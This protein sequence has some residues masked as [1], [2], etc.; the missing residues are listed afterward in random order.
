MAFYAARLRSRLQR[1]I[2]SGR[3]VPRVSK[4]T[5]K[6]RLCMAGFLVATYGRI[7]VAAEA[8]AG[9]HAA[10]FAFLVVYRVHR[11][12]SQLSVRKVWLHVFERWRLQ[13]ESTFLPQRR[14]H[15]NFRTGVRGSRLSVSG[16]QDENSHRSFHAEW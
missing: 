3:P 15:R 10:H 9:A 5:R 14:K 16:A 1:L 2:Q 4:A 12:R 7:E 8:Q 6:M 13:R 11:G